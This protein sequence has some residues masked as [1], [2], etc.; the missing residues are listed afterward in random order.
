MITKELRA[1]Q[2]AMVAGFFIIGLQAYLVMH[3]HLREMTLMLLDDSYGGDF[4]VVANGSLNA[5][6]AAIWAET[7]SSASQFFFVNFI[8]VLFGARLIASEKTHGTISLLLSRPMSRE[9]ILLT[10][11]AVNAFLLFV[12]CCL[13]G[14]VAFIVGIALGIPQP[15]AGTIA[16][17]FLLWLGTIFG[18]GVTLNYSIVI[19]SSLAAGVLGFV[20][21]RIFL[22][23]M[24]FAWPTYNCWASLNVY[25][26]I[27]NPFPL[28]G[29]SLILALVPLITSIILF[30]HKTY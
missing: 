18:L 15:M 7:F 17:I 13:C 20:T 24:F 16:S 19:P 11:F 2:W 28:L 10:K 8:S 4:S 12:L 23:V 22:L 29:M 6:S 5:S 25:A 14:V 30:Q 21:I 27:S 9:R 26:G 1:S 3:I